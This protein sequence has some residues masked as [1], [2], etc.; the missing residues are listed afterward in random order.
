MSLGLGLVGIDR[1]I[2]VP[3]MPVLMRDLHLDYQDLGHITG[4]LAIAWGFASLLTA[5]F[6]TGFGFRRV[7]VPATESAFFVARGPERACK[8]AW[9]A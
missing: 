9:A 7:L 2:I 6:P 3:L 8:P 5:T 4:A 1:F